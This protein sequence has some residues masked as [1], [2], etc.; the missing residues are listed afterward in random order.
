MS[1]SLPTPRWTSGCSMQPM[2]YIT[3]LPRIRSAM[4]RTMVWSRSR[5]AIS[6]SHRFIPEPN[7]LTVNSVMCGAT[8][9]SSS[10]GSRVRVLAGCSSATVMDDP[11]GVVVPCEGPPQARLSR[12]GDL[13]R[14][15]VT[16]PARS[17]V[18]PTGEALEV[19]TLTRWSPGALDARGRR[20]RRGRP[21]LAHAVW[22]RPACIA[23]PDGLTLSYGSHVCP[24]SICLSQ[25]R[26]VRAPVRALW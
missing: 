14:G 1:T 11:F 15:L 21:V 8:T 25:A 9:L 13:G 24:S 10:F 12:K 3:A 19:A 7:T 5:S 18:L 6:R 22:M 16:P 26:H 20:Q 4:S 17:S 23:P 2:V